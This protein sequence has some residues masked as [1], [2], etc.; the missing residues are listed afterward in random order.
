MQGVAGD[1][2]VVSTPSTSASVP[3]TTEETMAGVKRGLELDE[4]DRAWKLSKKTLNA[5]LGEVYDP[6]LIPIKLK[7]KKEETKVEEVVESAAGNVKEGGD[8]TGKQKW[9]KVQW[10][11]AEGAGA[12]ETSPSITVKVDESGP[13][14]IADPESSAKENQGSPM[15][16]EDENTALAPPAQT[17]NSLFRK[18]KTPASGPS[19][20]KRS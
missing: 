16:L 15:K 17:A 14:I 12:Q 7:V 10:Q 6:G 3:P 18:R 5:G 9:T 1:W 19:R 2:E 13:G 8:A 20:G 4:E 11:G